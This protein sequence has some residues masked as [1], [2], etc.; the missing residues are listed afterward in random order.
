LAVN[1]AIGGAQ[2]STIAAFERLDAE[3]E[4]RFCQAGRTMR[5]QAVVVTA[6]FAVMVGAGVILMSQRLQMEEG[7]VQRL[8]DT[9]GRQAK[10]AEGRF[11]RREREL[12]LLIDRF[13]S[14]GQVAPVQ[15]ATEA[16][17]AGDP[18]VPPPESQAVPAGVEHS[19]VPAIMERLPSPVEGAFS[20][21]GGP[22]AAAMAQL[23][24]ES[25]HVAPAP[26]DGVFA[27]AATSS[28]SGD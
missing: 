11:K 28:K 8:V 3:R 20:L 26:T 1:E 17:A 2:Q 23:R 27:V 25:D 21:V 12:D 4:E 10:V 16:P 5:R 22:W 13:A 24:M 15:G 9:V 18:E 19:A 6:G 14:Q 7:N